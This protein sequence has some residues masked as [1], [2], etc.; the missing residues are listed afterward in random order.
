MNI[1]VHNVSTLNSQQWISN[2]VYILQ[3][4]CII[5]SICMQYAWLII[6][7]QLNQVVEGPAPAS[8]ETASTSSECMRS[9]ELIYWQDL[10]STLIS[11]LLKGNHVF[12]LYYVILNYSSQSLTLSQDRC[13]DRHQ[14]LNWLC[15][16]CAHGTVC[17]THCASCH[18]WIWNNSR[19]IWKLIYLRNR[20]VCDCTALLKRLVLLTALY[21]LSTLH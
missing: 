17:L 12:R 2:C 14:L 19:N 15:R 9:L 21:K 18:H 5:T 20:T 13:C 11:R 3:I 16:A 10:Y 1:D 4:Y 6:Y 7:F 8:T